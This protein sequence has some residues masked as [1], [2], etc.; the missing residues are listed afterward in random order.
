MEIVN[1]YEAKTQLSRL[2]R[3]ALAGE[4][5]VIARAGKPLV[6]LK[7]CQQAQ[8]RTPGVW[9]GKVRIARDFDAP[10][11]ELE[12]AIHGHDS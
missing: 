3:R 6:E 5:I 4:R 10:I 8:R 2:I 7:P 9:K 12:A 1:C 11:P